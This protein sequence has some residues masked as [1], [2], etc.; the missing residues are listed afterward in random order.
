MI[1][2]NLGQDGIVRFDPESGLGDTL[3]CG[4][5]ESEE[6][7][8]LAVSRASRLADDGKT[9]FDG[10]MRDAGEDSDKA[11]RAALAYRRLL[12]QVIAEV[13]AI[14]RHIDRHRDIA[15]AILG[16]TQAGLRA[17][18]EAGLHLSEP[19]SQI[20]EVNRKREAD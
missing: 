19:G 1:Y 20:L 12:R 6:L 11:V 4:R 17:E 2:A 18:A 13:E 15:V 14:K 9:W 16:A 8:R 5:H 3:E 10:A 7:L